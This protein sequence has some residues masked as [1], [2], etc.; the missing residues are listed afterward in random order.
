MQ[1]VGQ[2]TECFSIGFR[3]ASEVDGKP[4]RSFSI[5]V[6]SDVEPTLSMT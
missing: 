2:T 4:A 5:A 3:D 6:V 1:T